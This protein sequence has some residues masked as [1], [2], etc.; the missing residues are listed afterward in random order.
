MKEVE[1]GN[2]KKRERKKIEEWERKCERRMDITFLITLQLTHIY[3]YFLEFLTVIYRFL[4][5]CL[6][7]AITMTHISWS[8]CEK[9]C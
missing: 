9:V 2:G 3:L 8:N 4:I 6:A 7:N 1:K 5:S